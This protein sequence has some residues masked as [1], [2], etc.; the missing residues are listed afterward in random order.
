MI[1]TAL[2]AEEREQWTRIPGLFARWR[3]G[4]ISTQPVHFLHSTFLEQLLAGCVASFEIVAGR[5]GP[6]SA[7]VRCLFTLR[8]RGNVVLHE[9][10]LRAPAVCFAC[11]GTELQLCTATKAGQPC[12]AAF[13][14]PCCRTCCGECSAAEGDT[15]MEG[16]LSA[17]PH[18]DK[19]ASS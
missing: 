16:G 8:H 15:N 1:I 10:P 12:T 18:A 3:M 14:S 13:T 9:T 19:H 17:A 6:T 5:M 4:R 7:S 11:A 2:P